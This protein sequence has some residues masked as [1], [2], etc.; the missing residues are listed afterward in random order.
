MQACGE[1]T[2]R[3]LHCKEKHPLAGGVLLERGGGKNGDELVASPFVRKTAL[4]R[5]QEV[6]PVFRPPFF[7]VGVGVHVQY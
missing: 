2:L 4:L 3:P 7:P 5:L 6:F 1:T